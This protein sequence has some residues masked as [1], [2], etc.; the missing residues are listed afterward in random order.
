MNNAISLIGAD[1]KRHEV[2]VTL[3]NSNEEQLLYLIMVTAKTSKFQDFMQTY[4]DKATNTHAKIAKKIFGEEETDSV[5]GVLLDL[6]MQM[7]FAF[8]REFADYDRKQQKIIYKD[9]DDLLTELIKVTEPP[10]TPVFPPKA[11]RPG[12]ALTGTLRYSLA[13]KK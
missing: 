7:I 9:V 1:L 11:S 12:S 4:G 6:D 8:N 3:P 10:K 5:Y 2:L 13:E